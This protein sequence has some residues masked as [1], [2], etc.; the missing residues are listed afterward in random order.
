MTW[1]DP[2]RVRTRTLPLPAFVSAHN[3][4][5]MTRRLR[6][7]RPSNKLLVVTSIA[8]RRSCVRLMFM[9]GFT[10]AKGP[11]DKMDI[12]KHEHQRITPRSPLWRVFAYHRG[13]ILKHPP[14]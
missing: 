13:S 10:L 1:I 11:D 5:T 7:S 3:D 8:F 4:L 9:A 6:A 14:A 2:L 12:R